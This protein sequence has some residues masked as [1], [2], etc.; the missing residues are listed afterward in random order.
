MSY[1][2][3]M[4]SGLARDARVRNC[5]SKRRECDGPLNFKGRG[6]YFLQPCRWWQVDCHPHVVILGYAWVPWVR[7]LWLMIWYLVGCSTCREK[8]ANTHC[9]SALRR[10]IFILFCHLPMLKL[11]WKAMLVWSE[12]AARP[13]SWEGARRARRARTVRSAVS[14][15][16]RRRFPAISAVASAVARV[17]LWVHIAS[18]SSLVTCLWKFDACLIQCDPISCIAQWA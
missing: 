14:S 11:T 2:C 17:G 1:H 18:F 16:E 10:V 15:A 4:R 7:I 5:C 3:A 12:A 8:Q 6:N 9:T 13:R